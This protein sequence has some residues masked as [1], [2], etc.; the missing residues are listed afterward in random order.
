[1]P[2]SRL[3]IFQSFGTTNSAQHILH[4]LLYTS[5]YTRADE[6][7]NDASGPAAMCKCCMY[8]QVAQQIACLWPGIWHFLFVVRRSKNKSW[9]D[10]RNLKFHRHSNLWIFETDEQINANANKLP[11]SWAESIGW[12][13]RCVQYFFKRSI[14]FALNHCHW[15]KTKPNQ[16][17]LNDRWSM[18]FKTVVMILEK[19]HDGHSGNAKG[20]RKWDKLRSKTWRSTLHCSS[21]NIRTHEI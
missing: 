2:F 1:M 7:T 8:K 13:S 9:S 11:W 18:I 14:N 19:L 10:V 17:K 6:Q 4:V 5:Y 12:S 20:H 21:N 15:H 3:Y 16:T